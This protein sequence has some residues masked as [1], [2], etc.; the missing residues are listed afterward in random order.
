VGAPPE[1]ARDLQPVRVMLLTSNHRAAGVVAAAAV[2]SNLDPR[3]RVAVFAWVDN[4][5][6]GIQEG[7]S[8][9]E[10]EP[11][12]QQDKLVVSG[13]PRSTGNAKAIAM[14]PLQNLDEESLF[15]QVRSDGRRLF[16]VGCE[17]VTACRDVEVVV[18]AKDINVTFGGDPIDPQHFTSAEVYVGARVSLVAPGM[19]N[20]AAA[21][22]LD[23]VRLS[24][25]SEVAQADFGSYE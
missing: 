1:F 21:I 4:A 19:C 3:M 24:G 22:L 9:L 13:Y 8:Y 7:G 15:V 10:F 12:D 23:R 17:A 2:L 5:L 25:P 14:P 6:G 18:M 11:W 16:G 20:E